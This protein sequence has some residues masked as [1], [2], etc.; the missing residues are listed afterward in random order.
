MRRQLA[1]HT[2][3]KGVMKSAA[4]Q[5]PDIHRSIFANREK[6]D[7]K[8][9]GGEKKLCNLPFCCLMT[10]YTVFLTP[11]MTHQSHCGIHPLLMCGTYECLSTD[12][13]HLI[14][15]KH[16]KLSSNYAE[17]FHWGL[18]NF[19]ND[20]LTKTRAISFLEILRNLF[21]TSFANN[22]SVSNFLS[23]FSLARNLISILMSSQQRLSE[24]CDAEVSLLEFQGT[25]M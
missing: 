21:E 17:Q 22:H 12:L 7:K 8:Q 2:E 18:E 4:R 20:A 6:T 3:R 19:F 11:K 24:K 13:N 15:T 10:R 16:F 25:K 9:S 23:Q 1:V 14:N 5:K